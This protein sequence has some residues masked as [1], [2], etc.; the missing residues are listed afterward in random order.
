MTS[1][2]G[3]LLATLIAIMGAVMSPAAVANAGDAILSGTITSKSA[4]LWLMVIRSET[5]RDVSITSSRCFT[6]IVA[7]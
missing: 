1:A 3:I 4:F 6:L 5:M 2:Y 7:S